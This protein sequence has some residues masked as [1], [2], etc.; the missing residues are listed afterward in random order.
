MHLP[1]GGELERGV[2]ARLGRARPP[3]H[4]LRDLPR[5]AQSKSSYKSSCNGYIA[6]KHKTHHLRCSPQ[7]AHIAQP[8]SIEQ[9]SRLMHERRPPSLAPS[10]RPQAHH[11]TSVPSP[12]VREASAAAAAAAAAHAARAFANPRIRRGGDRGGRGGGQGRVARA[13]G[14]RRT[15]PIIQGAY[16]L[17]SGPY[18]PAGLALRSARARGRHGVRAAVPRVGAVVSWGV[19]A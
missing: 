15:L 13:G 16:A 12:A 3:L 1:A 8:T 9:S 2:L 18:R 14:E 7:S 11:L 6:H 17:P 10:Q 5:T 4:V 19:C